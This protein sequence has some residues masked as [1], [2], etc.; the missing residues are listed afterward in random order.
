MATQYTKN[1]AAI[2]K[3]CMDIIKA[4]DN[5]NECVTIRDFK[6]IT[7]FEG[8]LVAAS[9]GLP[10]AINRLI[11]STGNDPTQICDK[12]DPET[13]DIRIVNE[14]IN[15]KFSHLLPHKEKRG[16]ETYKCSIPYIKALYKESEKI[17]NIQY[18]TPVVL[19]FIHHYAEKEDMVDHDNL[20]YKPFIDAVSVLFLKNDSP[21]QCSHF[22]DYMMDCKTFSE[23]YIVPEDVFMNFYQEILKN[24]R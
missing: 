3:K 5:I 6:L 11:T 2:K 16:V 14:I 17:N 15:I 9:R 4:V 22:M 10:D 21:R 23:I 7:T 1:I 24:I 8:Q 19:A 13:C 20:L 18:N 12:Y